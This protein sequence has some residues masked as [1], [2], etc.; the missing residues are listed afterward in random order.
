METTDKRLIDIMTTELNQL[1]EA[2]VGRVLD[3]RL[4]K[5]PVKYYTVSEV[6][7]ILNTSRVTLYR[8]KN[9]GKLPFS[10]IAGTRKIRLTQI[11]ID[12]FLLKNPGFQGK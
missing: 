6:S 11:D 5:P 8:L 12:N 3:Q 2:A 4:P 1:I 7:K 10:R 9:E